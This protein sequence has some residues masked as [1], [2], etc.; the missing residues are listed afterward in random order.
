V[1][2]GRLADYSEAGTELRDSF[3]KINVEMA[4]LSVDMLCTLF[5]RYVVIP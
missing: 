5:Y 4:E 1:T 2:N 3:A